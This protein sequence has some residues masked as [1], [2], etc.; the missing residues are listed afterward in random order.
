MV[1]GVVAAPDAAAGGVDAGDW[2]GTT[3]EADSFAGFTGGFLSTVWRGFGLTNESM[4]LIFTALITKANALITAMTMAVLMRRG[5]PPKMR[6]LPGAG[7][8]D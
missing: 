3:A 8:E 5:I 2:V 1:F 7:S 4:S 6:I